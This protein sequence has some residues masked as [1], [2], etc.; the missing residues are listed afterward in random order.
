MKHREKARLELYV[1]DRAIKLALPKGDD[2][3]EKVGTVNFGMC[4]GDLDV[5]EKQSLYAAGPPPT[6]SNSIYEARFE[7]INGPVF[8]LKRFGTRS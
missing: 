5:A 7:D 8:A 6:S 4:V 1:P 2:V 3:T